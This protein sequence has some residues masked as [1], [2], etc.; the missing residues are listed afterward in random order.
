MNASHQLDPG[1][2][3]ELAPCMA[4]EPQ[5]ACLSR[6]AKQEATRTGCRHPGSA[7]QLPSL[8]CD[9]HGCW[10]IVKSTHVYWY[11]ITD[12][13]PVQGQNGSENGVQ[14]GM[15]T[16][17]RSFMGS[18]PPSRRNSISQQPVPKSPGLSPRFS[19]GSNGS[20][21]GFPAARSLQH[22]TSMPLNM[23][24]LRQYPQLLAEVVLVLI[25]LIFHVPFE[26]CKHCP[27]CLIEHSFEQRPLVSFDT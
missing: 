26:R 2:W 27:Q 10:L 1:C 24:A 8:P 19:G 17:R 13:A 20:H 22:T 12:V 3:V 18:R 6:A 21:G 23:C 14:D 11:I 25:G 15:Q 9:N 4:P 16:P 7:P 5:A